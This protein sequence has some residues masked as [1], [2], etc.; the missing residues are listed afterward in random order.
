MEAVSRVGRAT[1]CGESAWSSRR[2]S[3]KT[4][5]PSCRLRPPGYDLA[6]SWPVDTG[7]EFGP[8]R[9]GIADRGTALAPVRQD[10]AWTGVLRDRRRDEGVRS[11]LL[12][13]PETRGL[14][15]TWF[16]EAARARAEGPLT[17][18]CTTSR[19]AGPESG[20]ASLEHPMSSTSTL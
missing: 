1:T 4:C 3:W 7:L 10:G 14:G 9:T 17:H 16:A 15:V 11:G 19:G 2:P 5:K 18:L 13:A 8:S 12:L 6:L 20:R